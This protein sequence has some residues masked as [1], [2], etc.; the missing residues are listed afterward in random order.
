MKISIQKHRKH[1]IWKFYDENKLYLGQI[2]GDFKNKES[3]DTMESL[4]NDIVG[5][6]DD[7]L[8]DKYSKEE[9]SDGSITITTVEGNIRVA[10]FENSFSEIAIAIS[11]NIK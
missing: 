5:V 4:A 1:P 6:L 7:K 8:S 9:S 2:L 10:S 3:K 11:D